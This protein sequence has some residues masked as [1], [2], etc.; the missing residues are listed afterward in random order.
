MG[1]R[2]D[3]PEPQEYNQLMGDQ[4]TGL[5]AMRHTTHLFHVEYVRQT[6]IRHIGGLRKPTGHTV[7][8]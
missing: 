6:G 2:T 7:P 5:T 1:N 3:G 4:R 8:A